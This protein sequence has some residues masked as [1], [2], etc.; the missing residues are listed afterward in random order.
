[1]TARTTD[2][3]DIASIT[4]AARQARAEVIRSLIARLFARRP[5]VSTSASG[6]GQP[7]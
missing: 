1:M 4:I 3:I 5:G 7:A 6:S 2:R